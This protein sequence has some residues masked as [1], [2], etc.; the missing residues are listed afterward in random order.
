[1]LLP[2]LRLL[3]GCGSLGGDA[4]PFATVEHGE[5]TISL[6][7]PG[8]LKAVRSKNV[9]APSVKGT[10]KVV[11]LVEEGAHVKAGDI[12]VEF[13][14]T[15]LEKER[16]GAESRLEIART[17]IAQKRAQ[18]AVT[19][20]SSQNE[21]TKAGLDLRRA[22]MRLTESET[23]PKVERE[24]AKL[25]VEQ[26]T[27]SV[28]RTQATAESV[29]LQGEAEL[30]L[31]RIEEKDAASKL[32]Q[33]E[34]QLT[35]LRVPA[36]SDGLV[37]LTE[38]WRAGKRGKATVGDNLW[39]GNPIMELPDLSL[40][41]V[42]AWVHEVD[43]GAVAVGQAVSVVVDAQPVPAWAAKIERVADLAVKKTE[44]STVKHVKLTIAL[45]RT[46]PTLKPGM[47]VRA[48]IRIDTLPDVVSIPR[49]A[50]F[51]EGAGSF[52]Y[53]RGVAG[54]SRVELALGRTNDARVVVSGGL[55]A[56]DVVALVDP[57]AAEKA[58]AP[59]A[60]ADP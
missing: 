44:E 50:V 39:P 40:M 23:V 11:A 53:R 56:G 30:E 9:S 41:Q 22:Q 1:M 26:Y 8:E 18:F 2:L 12:V 25:D 4:V 59:E 31:L 58:N 20:S 13:D 10:L 5:F 15:D 24:T 42:E 21:V 19:L 49:E 32:E 46:D 34:T 17:K 52:A 37:I 6:S 33:T 16:E 45:D 57:D 28:A 36:P 7:V 35:Q 54:W 43:A 60:S 51:H 3:F 48:E 14:A 38:S 29:R 27:L 47:T 55:E